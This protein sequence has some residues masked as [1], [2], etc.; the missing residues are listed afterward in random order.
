MVSMLTSIV[1]DNGF[2]PQSDQSKDYE[3]SIYCFSAKHAALGCKS[4]D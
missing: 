4:K 3:I 1:A 2:E